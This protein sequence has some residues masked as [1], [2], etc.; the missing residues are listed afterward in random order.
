VRFCLTDPTEVFGVKPVKRMFQQSVIS[1]IDQSPLNRGL[2][3]VEWVSDPRNIPIVEDDDIALFDFEQ[4]GVYQVHFLYKSRG[5]AAINFTKEAFKRMFEDHGAS[6]IFGLV[7][8]HRRDVKLMA[9]WTGGKYVGKRMTDEG[10]CEVFVLSK[11]MWNR[12]WAS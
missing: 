9:R 12:Q 7:P 6:M 11:D 8:D 2:E 5:K 1:A 4:S 10:L 3:G